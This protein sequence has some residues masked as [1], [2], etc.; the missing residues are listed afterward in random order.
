MHVC[1]LKPTL[2]GVPWTKAKSQ[3]CGAENTVVSGPMMGRVWYTV[4]TSCVGVEDV[5]VT[6]WEQKWVVE[7]VGIQH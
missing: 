1:A 3:S 5:M 2:S 6:A 7:V 4:V